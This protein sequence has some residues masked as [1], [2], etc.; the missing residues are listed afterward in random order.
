MT[1]KRKKNSMGSA[2][3]RFGMLPQA[4]PQKNQI[5]WV[6]KFARL[7]LTFFP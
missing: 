4:Y 5:A 6:K 2:L 1:S 7:L 3:D